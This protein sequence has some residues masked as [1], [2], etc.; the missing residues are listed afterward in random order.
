MRPDVVFVWSQRRLTLGCARAAQEM[1]A[2]VAYTFN[3]EYLEFYRPGL[4]T[5][6][7]SAEHLDL[8]HST[9]ISRKLKS[10]LL[11]QGFP[12]QASQVI[13]QGVPLDQFPCRGEPVSSVRRLLYVGQL[14]PYKGVHTAIE[15]VHRAR[16]SLTIVGSGP[17][18]YECELRRLAQSGP[19]RIVFLGKLPSDQVARCYREHDGLVFPSSWE[20][21][22]G[23]THL[24]AMA[25]GIPVLSTTNGGQGEFLRDG[26][27]CLT[28]EPEDAVGLASRIGQLQSSPDLARRLAR[29]GRRTVER[30][31]SLEGYIQRIQS[32]LQGVA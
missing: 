28:F 29:A 22:F 2:R 6:P 1:G 26:D 14:H 9:C 11:R 10:N 20:E 21:P 13:Y 19:G 8:S 17:G 31:F 7:L 23:L 30:S 4:F 5:G 16:L 12:L 32:F 27:N 3:D 25:S 24:E 18:H 15:A